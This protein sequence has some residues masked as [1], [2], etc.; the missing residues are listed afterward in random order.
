MVLHISQ[1]W[2]CL[3]THDIG[4]M[5][6]LNKSFLLLLGVFS[7]GTRACPLQIYENV[8]K[9]TII[10]VLSTGHVQYIST[11]VKD[12]LKMCRSDY[13]VEFMMTMIQCFYRWVWLVLHG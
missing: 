5:S 12:H 11:L 7:V 4:G 2:F 8:C 3:F 9:S 10:I 13:G 6:S 1:L